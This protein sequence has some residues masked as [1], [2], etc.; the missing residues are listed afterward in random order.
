[1]NARLEEDMLSKVI[2]RYNTS[3]MNHGLPDIRSKLPAWLGA[4]VLFF[5]SSLSIDC[6]AQRTPTVSGWVTDSITGEPLPFVTVAWIKGLSGTVTNG[7]GRFE[8]HMP[9]EIEDESLLITLLGYR[10]Q[11]VRIDQTAP[12]MRF[13]L[14][15]A[16]IELAEVQVNP[17]HPTHY[18]RLAMRSIKSN[19]P[20]K[21]FGTRSY[22]REI[23]RENG[24]FLRA[25]EGVF[26]SYIPNFQDTVRK[27]HQLLLFRKSSELSDLMFMKKEREKEDVKERKKEAKAVRKGKVVEKKKEADSLGIGELFGGPENL[28][29]LSDLFRNPPGSLDT[30]GFKNY[31]YT[32]ARYSSY[33]DATLMVIDFKSNGKVDNVREEGRIYLDI[34]SNAIV[35]VESRGTYVVPL[36][37][38]PLLLAFGFGIKNPSFRSTVSFR[39]AAGKWYPGT[40]LFFLSAQV[41]RKR[42]FS[43]NDNSLFEVDGLLTI[44]RIDPDKAQ[45]IE[46]EKQYSTRKRPENQVFAQPGITWEDVEVIKP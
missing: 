15:P 39:Q 3:G 27:Q 32:Y 7:D 17:L 2:C 19:Y 26:R 25:H 33:N 31:T 46:K 1:M 20:D 14:V 9:E 18:L 36:W 29:R 22:Y 38:R 21:P 23:I 8:I 24:A 45:P 13:R 41:E 43:A 28:L 16:S 35:R 34:A 6:L 44:S 12:E 30:I 37:A 11:V 40:T 10:K 42:L 4:V 5:F